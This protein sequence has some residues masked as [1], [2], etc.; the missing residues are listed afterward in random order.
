MNKFKIGNKWVGARHPTF[1]IAEAGINHQGDVT[2]A[3]QLIDIAFTAGADAVKFQKRKI[4]QMLTREALKTPYA[5]SNSFGNTY[6]EHREALELSEKDFRILKKYADAKFEGTDEIQSIASK[7][8][9][10]SKRWDIITCYIDRLYM[11]TT[12]SY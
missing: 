11:W 10:G 6:G 7:T 9:G 3:K 2:I 5:G 12:K 4:K 8:V 1:I